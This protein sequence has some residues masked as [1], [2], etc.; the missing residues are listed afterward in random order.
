MIRQVTELEDGAVLRS[1]VVIVGA[2]LAGIELARYLAGGGLRV[3]LLEGGRLEFDPAIQDLYR[4]SFAG[5]PLRTPETHPNTPPYLPQMYR[6]HVRIRQFGGTGRVWTGKWRIFDHWDFEPRPG[7]AHSGWPISLED[8]LPFYEEIAGDY[9]FGDFDA[10]ARGRMFQDAS[11]LLAPHGVIPHL[12]YWEKSTTRSGIRFF[13]ELKQAAGIDTVLGA[14]ATEIVLDNSRRRVRAVRFMSLGGR[15]FTVEAARFALAMGG[16][17]VPRLLLASNNQIPTGVGNAHGLVGRFFMDHP[18]VKSRKLIPGKAMRH[19]SDAVQRTRRPAFVLSFSLS[20]ELQRDL[21]LPNHAVTLHPVYQGRSRRP[22]H[23]ITHL[24]LEQVPNPESRVYLGSDL[25]ALKMPRL[26]VDWRFTPLDHEALK[27]IQQGLAAAFQAAGLG[28]LEFGERPLTLDEMFD[29]AHHMGTTRMAADPSHGVVD[30][31]CRVFGTEN[32]YVASSA[33]FATGHAY[34][35][36]YTI[37]ALA[38]RLARHLLD[39]NGRGSQN[40]TAERA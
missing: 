5:K 33:V 18:K 8:L 20:A 6:G 34:S 17:E 4:V 14:N 36:T 35:P 38:R 7:I 9:G 16:L 10:E 19:L 25:D 22:S 3:V 30:R 40:S 32:L 1:D 23:F 2:G 39:E 11:K 12:F 29:G 27:I 26:I 31:N 13:R 37:L 15:S 21:S 28:R 24:G